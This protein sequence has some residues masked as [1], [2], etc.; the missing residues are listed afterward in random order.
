[1]TVVVVKVGSSSLS[2]PNGGLDRDKLQH[3][4]DELA[5]LHKDGV[6]VLLVSSGAVAA[7]FT[8]LGFRRRPCSMAAR[9]AA[10]AV[11]QGILIE[12]YAQRLEAYGIT[13]A[14][15]L[16]TRGDFSDRVRYVNAY[17]TL[18]LLL[19]K[20]V[21]PIINE[22]DTVSVDE[23]TF[24]DNDRLSALVAGMVKADLLILLSDVDGLYT[25]NPQEVPD[26]RLVHD[27][28]HITPEI[29]RMAGGAGSAVGTGGMRTKVEAA[30]IATAAGVPVFLGRADRRGILREALSG[31]ARGT[32]FHAAGKPLPNRKQWLRFLTQESGRLE[33]DQGAADALITHGSSLL[34]S[35]VRAVEGQFAAGDVVLITHRG[36]PIGK[37]I[38]RYS[39]EQLDEMKGLR[40]EEI[41]SRFH[42]PAEPVVHRDEL[43]LLAEREEVSVAKT[44]QVQEGDRCGTN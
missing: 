12:E 8:K 43:V 2:N 1:L 6:S 41:E 44:V 31:R 21:I 17:N 27:V 42:M 11:G 24:G 3:I 33:V 36:E 4:V 15:I 7:G 18:T 30:K 34:A 22:N 39:S 40:S 25:A 28:P 20:R 38:A 9:Q 29:E 23:L 26:A 16:L 5:D 19:R 35:G 32:Y 13:A 14:Q 10:A 37:G